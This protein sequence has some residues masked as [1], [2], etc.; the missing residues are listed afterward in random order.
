MEVRKG[1][2]SLGPEDTQGFPITDQ[3]QKLLDILGK[4]GSQRPAFWF[5]CVIIWQLPK[6]C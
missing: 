6:K 4:P 2:W 3:T 1:V 5:S